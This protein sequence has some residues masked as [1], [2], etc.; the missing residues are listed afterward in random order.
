MPFNNNISSCKL[1]IKVIIIITISSLFWATAPLLGWSY[2]TLEEN[3]VSC[4]IK[5]N[6]GTLNVKSYNI[7]ILIFVF[8]IP[9][10]M[11]IITNTKS[12]ILVRVI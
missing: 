11:I 8:I 1:T 9:F 4:T 7:C 12:I 3:F 5:S 10:I 6:D 2:Y